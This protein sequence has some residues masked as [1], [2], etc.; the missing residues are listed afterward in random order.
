MQPRTS[1][2]KFLKGKIRGIS[3]RATACRQAGCAAAGALA[4]VEDLDAKLAKLSGEDTLRLEVVRHGKTLRLE[5]RMPEQLGVADAGRHLRFV[6]VPAPPL[7]PP[8]TPE[9]ARSP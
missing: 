8:W 2:T 5:T 3:L 7:P 6:R 1:L 4:S 9:T